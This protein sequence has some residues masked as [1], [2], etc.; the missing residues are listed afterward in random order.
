MHKAT[1]LIAR[2]NY[3]QTVVDFRDGILQQS[4]HTNNEFLR[5]CGVGATGIAKR[6]DM[7]EYDW[8]NMKYSAVTAARNMSQELG[9]EWPKNV[10]TVKPSGT[11]GKIMDT[12]EGIHKPLGMYLF[13]WVNFSVSDP[14]VDK[15]KRAGYRTIPN[16]A[17]K[18][19]EL[20]CIPVNYEGGQFEKVEVT[21]KDGTKEILD[22]NT[23]DAMQQLA[24]YKKIQMHYCDQNVSNT[25][26]YKPEEKD[27]IV[28]WLLDNWDI[29]VG[30]SFLFKQDPTM[31]AKDL[32]YDY[33]PQEY[34]NKDTFYEYFNSVRE[35]DWDDTDYESEM[36]A[37]GCAS[38]VCPIK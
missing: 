3:R 7:Q 25:I 24:R 12:Y 11:L 33:L 34:V 31:C 19:G 26:Y 8:K 6:D 35:I 20:V 29:Y 37:E 21:R 27:S 15:L 2:A 18:T 5:L 9:L 13:N 4:W 14:K 32:G 16:P 23:E 28:D 1:T 10:S 36:E 22:L 17:D 30:V 38:G